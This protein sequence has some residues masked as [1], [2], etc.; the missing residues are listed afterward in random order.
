MKYV[1]D[2]TYLLKFGLTLLKY[3]ESKAESC[4]LYRFN[5]SLDF[6]PNKM[7]EYGELL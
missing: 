7:K 6:T 4:T 1:Y 3:S 2:V 5:G